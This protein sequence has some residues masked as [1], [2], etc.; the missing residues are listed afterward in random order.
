MAVSKVVKA[1]TFASRLAKREPKA[2]PVDLFS[3]FVDNLANDWQEND[4]SALIPCA[5]AVSL[6]HSSAMLSH[7]AGPQ[8]RW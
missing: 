4:I 1:R 7:R 6:R 2:W 8:A 3:G 5:A